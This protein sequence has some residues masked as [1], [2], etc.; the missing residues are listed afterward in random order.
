MLQKQCL[1]GNSWRYRPSSK[2]EENSQINNLT[3]HL[4]ELEKEEQ[5]KPKVS[6]G[7]EIPK[8]REKIIKIDIPKNKQTNNRKKINKTKSW[9]FEKTNKIEKPLARLTKKRRE[10]TKI[11]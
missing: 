5:I 9:F 3:Y 4:N 8:T 2:K 10:K 7:K 11:K 6:R 1:D